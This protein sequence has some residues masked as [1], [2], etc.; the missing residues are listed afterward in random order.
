MLAVGSD[1][2]GYGHPGYISARC[3]ASRAS[4]L[5]LAATRNLKNGVYAIE[6]PLN[7]AAEVGR[8]RPAGRGTGP[9]RRWFS[10]SLDACPYKSQTVQS[11]IAGRH[12]AGIQEMLSFAA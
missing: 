9:S 5:S 3:F 11:G 4:R 12:D 8:L 2:D 7:G 10:T 1:K 6:I